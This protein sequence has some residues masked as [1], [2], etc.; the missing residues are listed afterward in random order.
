VLVPLLVATLLLVASASSAD[1]VVVITVC[2]AEGNAT[3]AEANQTC[4]LTIEN[5]VAADE[6]EEGEVGVES[7]GACLEG[8]IEIHPDSDDGCQFVDEVAWDDYFNYHNPKYRDPDDDD[9]Q[10]EREQQLLSRMHYIS[11]FESQIPPPTYHLQINEYTADTD[12]DHQHKTGYRPSSDPDEATSKFPMFEPDDDA[13]GGSGGGNDRNLSNGDAGIPEAVNWVEA[14][15]V[16]A[17]TNQGR[18]SCCWGISTVE[19]VEGAVYINKVNDDFL[20]PLSFQQMIS[21][22]KQND[23]CDGGTVETA[24]QYAISNSFGGL[25]SSDEYPFVDS[26]GTTTSTCDLTDKSVV[27]KVDDPRTVIGF[28]QDFPFDERVTKMKKAAARQ[29]VS[30]SVNTNCDTFTNYAGGIITDDGNCTCSS[31]SCIDHTVLLVGYNDTSNPPYWLIKNSWGTSWGEVSYPSKGATE[32]FWLAGLVHCK[33]MLIT[34]L[35]ARGTFLFV[36]SKDTFSFHRKVEA[37]GVCSG[38]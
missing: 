22:D 14:G 25:T 4:L 35:F 21:C 23:G 27:V 10:Q 5:G 29:P 36:C 12:V 34:P 1:D 30:I 32:F 19:A 7:C 8:Y 20:Q 3:C 37:T 33:V 24:Y 26:D 11:K 13:G 6:S 2:S 18:C 38:C 15:A 28:N 17:V 31:T 9:A 16:T